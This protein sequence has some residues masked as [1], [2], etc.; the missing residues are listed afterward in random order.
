MRI[1]TNGH[2]RDQGD[3]RSITTT[4]SID[5]SGQHAHRNGSSSD[6]VCRRPL[7]PVPFGPATPRN[8][9][10][11]SFPK[12]KGKREEVLHALSAEAADP[13]KYR[14]SRSEFL[15][16]NADP[17]LSTSSLVSLFQS[18][19]PVHTFCS[20][21]LT[22]THRLCLVNGVHLLSSWPGWGRVTVVSDE[23]AI[24]LDFEPLF[25]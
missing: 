18:L 2:H 19:P 14:L 17:L 10:V 12:W 7:S 5:S 3:S 22:T 21:V 6:Q 9:R 16:A 25:R 8:T 15:N 11:Q 13:L 4:S 23:R 24:C 1:S 20:P